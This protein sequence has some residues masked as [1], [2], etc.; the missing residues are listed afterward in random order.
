[1]AGA[2]YFQIDTQCVTLREAPPHMTTGIYIALLG[3]AIGLALHWLI[4]RKKK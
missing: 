3:A 1:V 4:N 2:C